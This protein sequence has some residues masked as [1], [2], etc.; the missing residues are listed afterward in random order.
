LKNETHLIA[1][2]TDVDLIRKALERVLEGSSFRSSPQCRALLQ[3]IVEQSLA[4]RD[5]MLRERL[6]GI[7]VFGRAPNYDAGNDPVVRSRVAEIRKRLAQHYFRSTASHGEIRIHIPTGKYHAVFEDAND[8]LANEGLEIEKSA[9]RFDGTNDDRDVGS[10]LDARSAESLSRESVYVNPDTVIK[11]SGLH[12]LAKWL[13]GWRLRSAFAAITLLGIMLVALRYVN[14]ANERR[15]DSFW[16]PI[17]G[18]NHPALIFIGANHTYDLNR[19]YL[20]KYKA[21]HNL[22][23]IGTEFFIDLKKGEMLDEGDLV[24]NNWLIGFGDVAAT[25]RIASVL[26]SLDKSYEIRYGNDITVSDFHSSPSILIGGF[27]NVWTMELMRNLPIRLES[28][29]NGDCIADTESK[30][31]VW[32]AIGNDDYA[33]ITRLLNS[34]TG[35]F[36]LIIAGIGTSGNQA[37]SNFLADKDRLGAVLKALP[38]A[39]ERKNLQIVVHTTIVKNVPA[40]TDVQAT[41]VW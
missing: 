15:F 4:G 2:K 13:P 20:A 38:K 28:R 40:L 30:T 39:W 35:N 14:A 5:E 41:R 6:I 37:A 8:G 32:R 29:E 21:E 1:A 10:A 17:T 9:Q 22:K 7:N 26:T 24:P 19:D 23:N 12:S 36:V 34:E 27:S 3:Y 31:R 16:A 25:A 18:S 11:P 33:V